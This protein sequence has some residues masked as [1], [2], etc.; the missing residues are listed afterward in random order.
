MPA[1]FSTNHRARS[2]RSL[3]VARSGTRRR[4]VSTTLA[5]ATTLA[6]LAFAAQAST[7]ANDESPNGPRFV[8]H[9]VVVPTGHERRPLHV[10]PRCHIDIRIGCEGHREGRSGTEL[11]VRLLLRLIQQ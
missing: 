10:Q 3:G 7:A 8:E 5:A 6:T 9:R 4:V 1:H 11:Q 2:S